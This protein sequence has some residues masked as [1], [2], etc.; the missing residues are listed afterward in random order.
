MKAFSLRTS[1]F[2]LAAALSMSPLLV[3]SA[4][5][6]NIATVNGK[7]I[8]KVRA[9]VMVEAQ[10][11]QGQPDTPELRQMVREE[12]IRREI[13]AQQA[14]NQGYEKQ[15][16]VLAQMM[17]ARQSVLI[18]AYVADYVA[19]HPVS[20]ETLK[21]EYDAIKLGLGDKEYKVRHILVDTEDE[22]KDII[23]KLKAG[24][25]FEEMAKASKDPGS[26]ER[27]GELG[28][29]TPTNYVAP[30]SAAMVKLENGQFTETPVKSEFGYHVIM[31]DDTRDL[32]LPS[33]EETKPQL[34]HRMQQQV[35]EKH[36]KEL[37]SKAKIQ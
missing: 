1:A 10:V 26:R 31:L 28:W 11:A 2:V 5:A 24:Q 33:F 37:M 12:L 35:I 18:N 19:K 14:A 34:A 29:A 22:A 8:P 21:K 17:L 23:S 3:G 25:K 30:F 6:Q 36:I 13:L 4:H 7:A 27:G 9:D 16:S 20:D 15:M 32:K